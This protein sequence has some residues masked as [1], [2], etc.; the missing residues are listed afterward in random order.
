MKTLTLGG[1]P[2]RLDDLGPLVDGERLRLRVPA[3]ALAQLKASR[4][5]VDEAV[6]GGEVVYG[7]TTGFGKL[8]NE[9][10]AREDL[11]E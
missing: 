3:P 4:A 10:V 2:L 9:A 5:M 7:L 6:R 11:R 8:K 1:D